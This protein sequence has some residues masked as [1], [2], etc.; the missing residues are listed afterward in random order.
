MRYTGRLM[1]GSKDDWAN[2]L[3]QREKNTSQSEAADR[4]WKIPGD[5]ENNDRCTHLGE[6]N[7]AMER[8]SIRIERVVSTSKILAQTI[9]GRRRNREYVNEV[10]RR[11]YEF[12]LEEAMEADMEERWHQQNETMD[13]EDLTPGVLHGRKGRENDSSNGPP[14]NAAR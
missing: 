10:G 14:V 9:D 5:P 6:Q 12:Y 8:T 11:V 4:D 1:E 3:A 13:V 7:L 2:I